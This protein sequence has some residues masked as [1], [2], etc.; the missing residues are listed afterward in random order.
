MDP[1]LFSFQHIKCPPTMASLSFFVYYF[2]Y[3]LLNAIR[4]TNGVEGFGVWGEA[5]RTDTPKVPFFSLRDR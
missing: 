2:V 1:W 4:Y 5:F 3:C